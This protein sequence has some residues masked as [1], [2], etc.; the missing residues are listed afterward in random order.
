MIGLGR[1]VNGVYKLQIKDT[2]LE[3]NDPDQF[4]VEPA[5]PHCPANQ[6]NVYHI[7]SFASHF[8]AN[9]FVIPKCVIW[10][11]RSGHVSSK[12]IKQLSQ[13][14]SYFDFDNNPTR[15]IFHMAKHKNLSYPKSNSIAFHS[16]ELL[17]LDISVP[18]VISSIQN[19][20]YFVYYS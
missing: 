11:F 5:I 2:H 4:C 20:R 16:F 9:N 17:H 18:L 10:H 15:D 7:I 1:Q 3:A 19:H 8:S 6:T 14:H 12:R 13:M